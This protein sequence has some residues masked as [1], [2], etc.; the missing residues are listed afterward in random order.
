M[1][2]QGGQR[3]GGLHG[4]RAGDRLLGDVQQRGFPVLAARFVSCDP[5]V[6]VLEGQRR[7]V[8][9]ADGE[10]GERNA[11][12]RDGGAAS[13]LHHEENALLVLGK[14]ALAIVRRDFEHAHRVGDHVAHG[15]GRDGDG[16][17]I[18]VVVEGHDERGAERSAA[19]DDR[20]VQ[21]DRTRRTD[22]LLGDGFE[23]ANDH[24]QAPLARLEVHARG[25]AELLN[26][27]G[28]GVGGAE[29]DAEHGGRGELLRAARVLV[30]L[31]HVVRLLV[32]PPAEVGGDVARAHV[33][34]R[35]LEVD[36]GG[37]VLEEVHHVVGLRLR[38]L[39]VAHRVERV[40]LGHRDPA[41]E[42]LDDEHEGL[43]HQHV[44]GHDG[45]E[46]RVVF[47]QL[48]RRK[49][50]AR[51]PV[52]FADGGQRRA[53]AHMLELDLLVVVRGR[54]VHLDDD[55]RGV[56]TG[57]LQLQLESHRAVQGVTL[58]DDGELDV[59]DVGLDDARGG[60]AVLVAND[61]L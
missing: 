18:C 27:D 52:L 53:L 6:D 23:V 1:A 37:R 4:E 16:A 15:N 21:R 59:G 46:A 20:R 51:R 11:V 44:R 55:G 12:Q 25:V 40:E 10:H 19:A 61:L 9:E 58:F 30:V 49:Q 26:R 45:V 36:L 31:L 60:A 14:E 42:R 33:D 24:V 2:P 3:Q 47:A 57:R 29:Q 50:R 48:A 56:G 5:V 13:V 34:Q 32:E 41:R 54:D 35:R 8:S 28:A 38:V 17:V 7:V 43:L 22:D 39:G